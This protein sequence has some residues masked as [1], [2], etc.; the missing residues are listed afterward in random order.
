MKKFE[1]TIRPGGIRIRREGEERLTGTQKY[2]LL[3]GLLAVC[4]ALGVVAMLVGP[5][6]EEAALPGMRGGFSCGFL[7]IFLEYCELCRNMIY[8]SCLPALYW[9]LKV[10]SPWT[11]S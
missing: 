11:S 9:Q 2:N 6:I 7:Y 10:V 1:I 8:Y 3:G 4:C 5:L